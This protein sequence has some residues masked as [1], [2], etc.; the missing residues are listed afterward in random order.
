MLTSPLFRRLFLPYFV[1]ICC[2]V[3][4]LGFSG[5]RRLRA[6]HLS[7]V[8]RKLQDNS[9]LIARLLNDPHANRKVR[10]QVRELGDALSCRITLIDPEGK[11][12]A[13]NEADVQQ[14]E[15]HRLRPEVMAALSSGQGI[16]VRRSG[17]VRAELV[18]FARRIELAGSPAVLRLSVHLD[19]LE[20]DLADLYQALAITAAVA[21]LVAGAICFYLARRHAI[22]FVAVTQFADSLSRGD[23]SHRIA[24]RGD[25][26]LATLST[27]LN[28]MAESLA[29]NL[30]RSSAERAQLQAVLSAMSEGVIAT[31][32]EQ[33]ILLANAAA[34]RLL[35]FDP[36]HATGHALWEVLRSDELIKAVEAALR[37][38]G[39]RSVKIGP[40]VG[41]HLEVVLSPFPTGAGMGL[42]IAAHDTT[43]A[44]RYEELRE[45]F[46]ANVSHELRT[47]IAMIK[48]F[49]ETLR[50]GAS[51]DPEKLQQYLATIEKHADLLTNLVTDLLDLA[52]LESQAVPSIRGHV[53]LQSVL[54]H[55]HEM[56]APTA[57]QK[58]QTIELRVASNLPNF[59]GNPDYIERAIANLLDNAIKYS[60]DNTSITIAARRENAAIIIEVTDNGIG[61]P[62]EDLP[63]IFERFYRVD[64]SRSRAMGGTGLGLSIVKHVAQFHGGKVEATSAVGRGSTFAL[65]LPI[66]PLTASSAG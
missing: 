53:D 38:K 25:G 56:Y 61:I 28:T 31:D 48:G 54:Q 4:V 2:C 32:G 57:Q 23:L 60:L 13:D 33:R 42:V 55:V 52:K 6:T 51:S 29:D 14:M 16:S 50:N 21:I 30:A 64:R 11:V 58:G 59:P 24:R 26:E 18:Y 8:E 62:P 39:R 12:L 49:A 65:H 19:A 41:R 17:T 1:L 36:T 44:V 35:N 46:V 22:P 15:N 43:E 7:D 40:I 9:L 47:P 34:A 10:E 66:D 3:G 45:E 20:R 5:A 63:R 37:E 27:A